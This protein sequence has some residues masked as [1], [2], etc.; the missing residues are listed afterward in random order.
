MNKEVRQ[1]LKKV[2]K[3]GWES[4]PTKNGHIKLTHAKGSVF[5]PSSPSDWRS[6]KDVER[7]M[8]KVLKNG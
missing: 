7:K 4:E 3:E 1:F 5:C 2:K 6:L 8:R